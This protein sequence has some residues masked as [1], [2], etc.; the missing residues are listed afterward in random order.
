MQQ[1]LLIENFDELDSEL[2]LKVINYL[3]SKNI[4][5]CMPNVKKNWLGNN[6]VEVL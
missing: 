4:F 5:W 1:V 3:D 2:R 6:Y